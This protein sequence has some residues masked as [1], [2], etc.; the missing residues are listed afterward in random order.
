[1]QCYEWAWEVTK[2]VTSLRVD[3]DLSVTDVDTLLVGVDTF[4]TQHAPPADS[5]FSELTEL[6]VRLDSQRL[7][8]QCISVKARCSE[9]QQLLDIHRLRLTKERENA[10]IRVSSEA[11]AS[12]DKMTT[13]VATAV[14]SDAIPCLVDASVGDGNDE[15]RST[16][17]PRHP[18]R[19][20][21]VDWNSHFATPQ[22]RPPIFTQHHSA[23]HA[24]MFDLA[25]DNS[26]TTVN[27]SPVWL[28]DI[29]LRRRSFAGMPSGQLYHGLPSPPIYYTS[30]EVAYRQ[31]EAMMSFNEMEENLF[32]DGLITEN[33]SHRVVT[34][35]PRGI[36]G[37]IVNAVGNESS[38]D[39]ADGNVETEKA[40]NI[41]KSSSL[42][43]DS[44]QNGGKTTF[45]AGKLAVSKSSRMH[46]GIFRKAMSCVMK[47][48]DDFDV[49]MGSSAPA[50]DVCV[51]RRQGNGVVDN[52]TTSLGQVK[53]RT[54]SLS[55]NT[56]NASQS[57]L[58]DKHLSKCHSM[59]TTSS[60]SLPRYDT[61]YIYYG[62]LYGC[63]LLSLIN[64][65]ISN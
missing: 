10:M 20:A 35:L 11:N 59:L 43:R 62:R 3:D 65:D 30:A 53:L 27:T 44:V 23:P 2:F 54:Q 14:D 21:S 34:S 63:T 37:D 60:E 46:R 13:A 25:L 50:A 31:Q 22:F 15:R 9:A 49:V 24:P 32:R 45:S 41:K 17:T 6:S 40:V 48:P 56:T 42:A 1:M 18:C 61:S 36:P 12:L 4:S 28:S 29:A 19:S 57:S 16:F 58:R 8:E 39:S 64:I 33:L 7:R 51:P 47:S 5:V 52:V 26:D 55:A 38:T